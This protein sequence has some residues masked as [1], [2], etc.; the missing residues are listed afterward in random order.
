MFP[1]LK[2][3]VENLFSRPSTLD[4]PAKPHDAKPRYR[5]RIAYDAEKCVN[6]GSCIKVCSPGAITVEKT[7]AEGG[8]D[9]TY[10]FDLTSCT[11]CGTC[12]DFCDTG[13]I[14]LTEDYHM[15]AADPADLIVSGTHFKAAVAGGL[16]VSSNCIY[17][18]LCARSCPEGAITV[19]RKTKHWEVDRE[20]CI[21]CGI[22]IGKCPKGALS[23]GDGKD[24]PSA[25]A[26]AAP[27]AGSSSPEAAP[28]PKKAETGPAAAPK[29]EKATRAAAPARRAEVPADQA[30]PARYDLVEGILKSDACIYCT[31][32]ARKCPME[33]L[34]VDR[35]ART[36]TIDR[37][38][39]VLCCRCL[40]ACPREALSVGT[41]G[42]EKEPAWILPVPALAPVVP[43][44]KTEETPAPAAAP[45]VRPETAKPS[46][47]AVPP[48]S[49]EPAPASSAEAAPLPAAGADGPEGILKSDAC[50]YCTLC[51]KRCPMGCL[52]VDRAAKTWTIDRDSC[53]LC[54]RCV[55][56]CPKQALSLGTV[57]E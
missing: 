49:A 38:T 3:A 1:F 28:A 53:I 46:A 31:V 36:W 45:A 25:E 33:A 15:V 56:A 5:G 17:C 51:A 55:A 37:E 44:K 27:D 26:P 20:K 34:T 29:K 22:C 48:A 30:D 52:E 14:R 35:A 43:E 24:A 11:F 7:P 54:G 47:Q 18:T 2:K 32:C 40:E 19:D 8:E 57:T 50:I 23:F 9:I 42:L 41:F 4:Y 39:C 16:T 21:Q 12:E 13:A 10:R 6:C